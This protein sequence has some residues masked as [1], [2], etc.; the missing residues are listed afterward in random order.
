MSDKF[1]SEYEKLKRLEKLVDSDIKKRNE[2]EKNNKPTSIVI[3][4]HI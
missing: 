3:F 4:N 2:F 1:T